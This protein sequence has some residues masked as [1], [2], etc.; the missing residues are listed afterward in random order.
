MAK[1]T[2]DPKSKKER[3]KAWY[4]VAWDGMTSN[5]ED[6]AKA[7]FATDYAAKLKTQAEAEQGTFTDL[8]NKN[9]IKQAWTSFTHSKF[10][11]NPYVEFASP[12]GM[13][14]Y[15]GDTA[16]DFHSAGQHA[17]RGEYGDAIDTAAG[18]TLNVAAG[19]VLGKVFDKLPMLRKGA[20]KEATKGIQVETAVIAPKMKPMKEGYRFNGAP[21]REGI[22]ST[23]QRI[24][25]QHVLD[26]E[27]EKVK[28][29]VSTPEGRKRLKSLHM[30]PDKVKDIKAVYDHNYKSANA[31][32]SPDENT[33]NFGPV[34]TFK[35]GTY[36]MGDVRRGILEHEFGH[37]LQDTYNRGFRDNVLK[38]DRVKNYL[39]DFESEMFLS[40]FGRPGPV[41]D[42]QRDEIMKAV[43]IS[44]L[45]RK[46]GKLILKGDKGSTQSFGKDNTSLR[47][48]IPSF[49][50][51]H[52][53][54]ADYF[55]TGSGENERMPFLTETRQDM[56][57]RGDIKHR[58]QKVTP[59]RVKEIYDSYKQLPLSEQGDRI[60]NI[61]DG[62]KSEN[63][64]ILARALNR[65]PAAVGVGAGLGAYSKEKKRRGGILYKR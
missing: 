36:E 21:T 20:T 14:K 31:F 35:P 54:S 51:K 25:G 29:A 62:S 8:D 37:G 9:P 13:A 44:P 11:N 58:H 45:D 39:K 18:A 43:N 6:D 50:G 49:R 28:Q 61:I 23:Q 41:W 26:A 2:N 30:D 56:L 3:D 52:K 55:R 22:I 38:M 64:K 34:L 63:F 59:E 7:K 1:K 42:E 10:M 5:N 32:Y 17:T 33:V 57:S 27:L 46:L 19:A 12:M 47:E 40:R 24:R 53:S 15:V 65:L 4:E 60:F 16:A 48:D